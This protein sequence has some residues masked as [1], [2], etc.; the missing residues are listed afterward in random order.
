MK[1]HT[2]TVWCTAI[3]PSISWAAW[4]YTSAYT[5]LKALSTDIGTPEAPIVFN[6]TGTAVFTGSNKG[7]TGLFILTP[8]GAHFVANEEMTRSADSTQSKIAVVVESSEPKSFK[9]FFN[10]SATNPNQKITLGS[11]NEFD[12][13][14]ELS[15]I[16]DDSIRTSINTT[17]GATL[18]RARTFIDT[19]PKIL[20]T[21]LELCEQAYLDF[22]VNMGNGT[23][24]TFRAE[25]KKMQNRIKPSVFS[26][27]YWFPNKG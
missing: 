16:V 9:I 4:N 14:V 25:L 22:S 10:P 20:K 2:L 7:A 17:M 26:V 3:A 6:R 1:F 5:C 27:E 11:S 18:L 12:R 19:N 23:E 8:K 21:P 24:S 15:E 13:H